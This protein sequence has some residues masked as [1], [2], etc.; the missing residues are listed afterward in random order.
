MRVLVSY[1]SASAAAAF[2]VALLLPPGSQGQAVDSRSTRPS[3]A[4]PHFVNRSA[5]SDRLDIAV[6]TIDKRPPMRMPDI[7]L[8]GCDP[9]FSP[10]AAADANFPSR[11]DV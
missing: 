11:C 1:L 7:I 6:T 5:K 4:A 8:V 10:L 9:A 2:I 3:G